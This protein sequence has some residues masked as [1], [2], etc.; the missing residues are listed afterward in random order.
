MGVNSANSKIRTGSAPTNSPPTSRRRDDGAKPNLLSPEVLAN[1]NQVVGVGI[2][3]VGLVVTAPSGTKKLFVSTWGWLQ[4]RQGQVRHHLARLLP[5]LRRDGTVQ[6]TTAVGTAMA[7]FGGVAS[8]EGWAWSA[9]SPA[10]ERIEAL[11]KHLMEVEG[12]LNDVRR[13]LR[14]ETRT[15]EQSLA[16][17][18]RRI[19][20][21]LG[22]LQQS[23]ISRDQ[24]SARIDAR[25]LPVVAA[26]IVLSGL[27]DELAGFLYPLGWLWVI[28]AVVLCVG[29]TVSAWRDAHLDQHRLAVDPHPDSRL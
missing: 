22:Q 8:A 21:E 19:R 23:I 12:R 1:V 26:G 5:F 13:Q 2:A 27:P 18:E 7:T 10:D 9:S 20:L 28:I 15:R 16:E 14:D 29:A 24:Q 4:R 6:G 3:V 17:L 11:R 25:G